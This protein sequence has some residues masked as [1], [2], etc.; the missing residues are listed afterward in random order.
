MTLVKYKN[1]LDVGKPQKHKE[2][3]R[4][5]LQH[6]LLLGLSFMKTKDKKCV[7]A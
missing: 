5:S 6:P 7:T 2:G 1:G 3:P 4:G